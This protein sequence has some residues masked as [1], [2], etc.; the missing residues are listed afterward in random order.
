MQM[1][2]K[3]N[4]FPNNNPLFP[5]PTANRPILEKETKQISAWPPP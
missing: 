5:N 4:P 1:C 2:P 3:G